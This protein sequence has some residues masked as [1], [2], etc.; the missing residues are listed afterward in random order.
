MDGSIYKVY[1]VLDGGHGFK[2]ERKL[3]MC[4]TDYSEAMA[5]AKEINYG[6]KYIC[7]AEVIEE[8]IGWTSRKIY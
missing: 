8:Y 5:K 2:T 7:R 6:K 3:I 1:T 4:T